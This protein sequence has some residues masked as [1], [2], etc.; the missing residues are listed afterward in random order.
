MSDLYATAARQQANAASL[1][2]AGPGAQTG[3][4]RRLA[5]EMAIS[6]G[7]GLDDQTLLARAKAFLDFMT[8]DGGGY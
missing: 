4:M 5:L 6:S 7:G 8:G 1:S 3:H 2:Y